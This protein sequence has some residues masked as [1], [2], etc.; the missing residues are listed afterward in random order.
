MMNIA[1]LVGLVFAGARTAERD[2]AEQPLD[3]VK[4]RHQ[5][6]WGC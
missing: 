5:G 1:Q 2:H 3:G 6:L 4:H